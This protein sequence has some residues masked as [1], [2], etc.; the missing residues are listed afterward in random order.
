M[1]LLLLRQGT[2]L[3]CASVSLSE[4]WA[5]DSTYLIGCCVD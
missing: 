1:P 3:L 2:Q 4:K 5:Y